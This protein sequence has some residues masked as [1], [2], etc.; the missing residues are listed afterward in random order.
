MNVEMVP[1]LYQI[2]SWNVSPTGQT[3]RT[4][5]Q[6]YLRKKPC[7]CGS[8]QQCKFSVRIGSKRGNKREERNG[9]QD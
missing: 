8:E 7:S 5:R 4:S 6:V 9:D 1:S 3:K 2:A